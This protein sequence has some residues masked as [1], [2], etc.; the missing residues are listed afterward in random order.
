MLKHY[1]CFAKLVF[2]VLF[3]VIT[4]NSLNVF[5]QSESPDKA[6]STIKTADEQLVELLKQ[7]PINF[8]IGSTFSV[9]S[10]LSDYY[11]NF[12]TT[13]LGFSVYA[14]YTWTSMPLAIGFESDFLFIQS[15]TMYKDSDYTNQYWQVTH[16]HDTLGTDNNIIPLSV[17]VRYQPKLKD[18]FYFFVEGFAG[19]NNLNVYARIKSSQK[20][21][22]WRENRL[23]SPFAYGAGLGVW[24]RLKDIIGLPS[25][26]SSLF[27][28]I[29]LRYAKGNKTEWWKASFDLSVYPPKAQYTEFRTSSD[30]ILFLT[31]L[32]YVF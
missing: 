15:N 13:P 21:S 28:E 12:R 25:H 5:C 17:F 7:K 30:L 32:T 3:L 10:P 8:F 18:W 31:G 27:A 16:F 11:D 24:L 23:S 14:G 19:I 2:Y 4:L 26:H 22:N 20:S 1:I 9:M 29:K 6:K